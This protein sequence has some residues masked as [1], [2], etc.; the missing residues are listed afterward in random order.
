MKAVIQDKYGSPDA[1]ELREID[2]PLFK[3]D[4]VLV[5]VRAA[6]V[7]PDVWHVVSGLPY[8]RPFEIDPQDRAKTWILL[9][10]I[11]LQGGQVAAAHQNVA[12]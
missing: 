8:I 12:A 11:G 4:E 6:S 9:F 10:E 5:R 7:H 2:E 3:D 1:L